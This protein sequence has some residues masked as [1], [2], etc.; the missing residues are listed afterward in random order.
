MERPARQDCVDLDQ[1]E[2]SSVATVVRI[3]DRSAESL[4]ASGVISR[5]LPS[6][7]RATFSVLLPEPKRGGSLARLE[8]DSLSLL[9]AGL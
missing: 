6:V 5:T 8:P 2:F 1:D 9:R 3:Y 7:K 4:E